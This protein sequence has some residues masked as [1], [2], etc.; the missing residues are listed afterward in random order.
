MM[1]VL[2][3]DVVDDRRRARLHRALKDF[4]S[5]VQR[6]VFELDLSPE[7]ADKMMLRVRKLVSPEEDT[8]RLY[9]LCKDCLNEVRIVGEGEPSID[10]DYYII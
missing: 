10:P 1:Y 3:Y 4:G 9:R 8:I 7:E 6:S 5:G 2:V